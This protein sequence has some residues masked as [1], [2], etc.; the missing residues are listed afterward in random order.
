MKRDCLNPYSITKV[1]G[2]DIALMYHKLY[3]ID[4]LVF[5]Y[6]NVYGERQPTKGQYAPVVGLFQKMKKNNIEMTVVGDG[7]ARR[8]Y[9]HVSDVVNANILAAQNGILLLASS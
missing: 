4:V 2:E 6:F 9:T 1:A 5:R 3:S 7:K 8:D